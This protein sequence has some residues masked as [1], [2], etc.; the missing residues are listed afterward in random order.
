MMEDVKGKVLTVLGPMEPGQLGVTLPHE[1]LLLDFTDATM[2]PGYCRA[3][4]LA[5][6]K[7]EMQNLGKIRQFPYSV[8]E[9]LTIDNVDQTTKELKLFKAAGGSTIVDVTS[10]GIRRST[11]HL[12]RISKES[13]VN[14]IV[15]TSYY[16]DAFVPPDAKL[17][18]VQEL[19]DVMVREVSEGVEGTGVRCGVIGEVGVSYPM[20]D[21]EKRSLQ[22]SAKAQ[23]I[24]GA[25]LIIHPGR[26]QESPSAILDVLEGAGADLSRTVMSHLD[27]TVFS[28]EALLTLARRGCYLE[29][30]LFGIET[31]HY[32]FAKE[33][34]MPSDAQRVQWV[35]KLVEA[36][37]SHRVMLS[38]DIHT[39]H[40]LVAYGGHGYGHLLENVVPKMKDRGIS[41]DII[42][43]MITDNPQQ[44]LTFV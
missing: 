30:D 21:F 10:I 39:K 9:N 20:T 40:R 4:E 3:D 14:I 35:K 43:S 38:H 5:M 19:C 2:D 11:E 24:T 37:F 22:A 27:R 28:E 42:T 32:P 26:S 7:L 6:L 12:P 36:G 23:Q 17:L 1:H 29:Y 8:R 31:S 16:V 34:D 13:G 33:V 41:E 15:G 44:W 18:S 25:P